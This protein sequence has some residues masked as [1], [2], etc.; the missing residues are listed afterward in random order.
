MGTIADTTDTPRAASLVTI[1]AASALGTTFEW[2][3][4]FVFGAL[5]PVIAK[6]F[7][8]GLDPTSGLLAALALFG[9]G[10]FFR[11]VGALIF[12]RIGDRVG[13]KGTFLLTVVLMGGSTF[14][15][16]ILPTWSQVGPLAPLLLIL[17][18]VVQG[19]ALGGEYGGAAIFVAEHA[20]PNRRGFATSFVQA[21]AAVGL[22]G[23]LLVIL[24]VREW[25]GEAGFTSGGWT[26][27]WRVPF[28]LSAGLL[29]ISI[30]M[31]L[32]LT[33]SP[34]FAAVKAAGAQSKAPFAE[35][36]GR[37]GNLKIVLIALVAIM[38]AQGAAWYTLFFYAEQVFLERFMK[39]PPATGTWLLILLSVASAPLYV[40]FAWLSDVVGRKWVMWGGMALATV[41]FFPAFHELARL[42]NP[43]LEAAQ[44]R[45]PVV[46]VADP[47]RCSFQFDL[48]GK[49]HFDT[50]CDIAK[51]VLSN[52]GISYRNRMAPPGV[53][54]RVQV[55]DVTVV[56]KDAAGLAPAARTAVAAEVKTQIMAALKAAGYPAKA[57]PERIDFWGLFWVLMIFVVACTALFGPIAA[58]LVELF[59]TRIRY[60]AMSLPYHVGTGWIGG[61]M[62]VTAFAIVTATGNIYAG[63]WYS[64]I[65]TGLSAVTLPFLL[66][67]TRHRS[68]TG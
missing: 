28:L 4:F 11:P 35:A 48:T 6:N 30:W 12:G 13:R 5:T 20:P 31:R 46:V 65:F 16:G 59:P 27:G 33:E 41:A 9:T 66:P 7:F 61:F 44:A 50:A 39:L 67:E 47:A 62:P 15:I 17:M 2:Y 56:S 51:S 3:D 10:F 37:W 36:F 21:A 8:A 49:G 26:G 52:G 53:A 18:R 25:Q 24:W 55:G 38:S 19:T 57:D 14:A 54:A 60:T 64:V 34:A 43:D 22:I 42:A 45:T 63:L 32:K 68:L 58:T 29:A 40:F 23:A 1:V